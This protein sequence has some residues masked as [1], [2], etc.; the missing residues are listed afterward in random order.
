MS[1]VRR[2]ARRLDSFFG[3]LMYGLTGIIA[4]SL[5]IGMAAALWSALE[6]RQFGWAAALG[7]LFLG[8]LALTAYCFSPRR[9]LSDLD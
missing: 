8:G 1:A 6:T 4:A 9:R 7:P 2:T 5:T 3:R